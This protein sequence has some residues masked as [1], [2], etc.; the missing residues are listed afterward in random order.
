MLNITQEKGKRAVLFRILTVLLLAIIVFVVKA[1][2]IFAPVGK[3]SGALAYSADLWMS[4]K[5]L[6]KDTH[7]ETKLPGMYLV[8]ALAISCLGKSVLA[9][10]IMDEI[11]IFLATLAIYYLGIRVYNVFTSFIVS[12]L[13]VIYVSTPAL[14]SDG[15]VPSLH[16][17]LPTISA[18]F[19]F[20]SFLQ[21]NRTIYLFSSGFCFGFA[22][23]IKQPALPEVALLALFLLIISVYNRK[24][25][26]TVLKELSV[27][28]T[29]FTLPLVA[30]VV[31]IYFKGGLNDMIYNSFIYPFNMA[32]D[33]RSV[34]ENSDVASGILSIFKHDLKYLSLLFLCSLCIL[35]IN[36]TKLSS[37][38]LSF[39]FWFIGSLAGTL[40]GG[41]PTGHYFAQVI[42]AMSIVI[43]AGIYYLQ[44]H[45]PL[46]HKTR[47]VFRMAL[48]SIVMVCILR[49]VLIGEVVDFRNH[50]IRHYSNPRAMTTEE[51]LADFIRDNTKPGD[52]VYGH[53]SHS[54]LRIC[55]MADR[56]FATRHSSPKMYDGSGYRVGHFP[57]PSKTAW[58][59]EEVCSDIV[60]VRPRIILKFS[61]N[62]EPRDKFAD[63]AEWVDKNYYILPEEDW[64]EYL[65]SVE[66][67][68][69]A[70][71]KLLKESDGSVMTPSSLNRQ[72]SATTKYNHLS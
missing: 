62:T 59:L 69:F 44:A 11:W 72:V 6:Y 3:D 52:Y 67:K 65:K 28:L 66:K 40:S 50:F 4:G 9:I 68:Y 45:E 49:N 17:V 12:V 64:P 29:C 20:V 13:F 30:F 71:I 26:K 33:G 51:K 57:H 19:F 37:V 18:M 27:F 15:N 35:A 22:F 43:G 16:L 39:L 56:Y 48:I 61:E 1:D 23:L 54:Y 58:M 36:L 60:R 10:H 14:V 21:K 53:G 2:S 25:Y 46:P 24:H 42:P 41:L 31:Y 63:L 7:F 8:D 38:E 34:F 55:F 32:A 5:V 70:P 47:H